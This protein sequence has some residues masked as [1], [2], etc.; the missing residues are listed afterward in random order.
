MHPHWLKLLDGRG[1]PKYLRVTRLA[2]TTYLIRKGNIMAQVFTFE[3]KTHQ[4][5][6]DIQIPQEGLFEATLVDEN[7]HR[8]EMIFRNGILFRLT[9]LD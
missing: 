9:E 5:A 3:G 7:N 8:C 2:T 4:F 1:D 6:E